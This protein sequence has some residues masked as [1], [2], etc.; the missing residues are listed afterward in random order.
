MAN[1]QTYWTSKSDLKHWT[2][3][4]PKRLEDGVVELDMLAKSLNHILD[5][6]YSSQ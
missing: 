1:R 5:T 6:Y 2:D 3:G 4:R